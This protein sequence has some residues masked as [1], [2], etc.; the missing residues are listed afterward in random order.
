M[1][2]TKTSKEAAD[3][4]KQAL[5]NKLGQANEQEADA[6]AQWVSSPQGAAY[7]S[8]LQQSGDYALALRKAA[9]RI[10]IDV[11]GRAPGELEQE[12]FQV[13]V[14]P[15]KQGDPGVIRDIRSILQSSGASFDIQKFFDVGF[16]DLYGRSKTL[17]GEASKTFGELS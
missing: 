4:A 3:L 1:T 9:A 17:E 11:E 12:V 15:E 13:E 14:D 16:L 6:V 2:G 10:G 7:M 8:E 5:D